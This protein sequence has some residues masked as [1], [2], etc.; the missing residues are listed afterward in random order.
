MDNLSYNKRTLPKTEDEN[1][2]DTALPYFIIYY[3]LQQ[4]GFSGAQNH[5]TACHLQIALL[6]AALL[7]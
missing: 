4:L 3:L 6:H 1:Q 7:F 2:N 5:D